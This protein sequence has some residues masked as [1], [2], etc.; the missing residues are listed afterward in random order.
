MHNPEFVGDAPPPQ[1]HDP[2][3][4]AV[5]IEEFVPLCAPLRPD[6][7]AARRAVSG[8]L[9]GQPVGIRQLVLQA[10]GASVLRA[11]SYRLVMRDHGGDCVLSLP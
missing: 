11:E 2:R 5:V 10:P 1:W 6:H 3:V 9:A 7:D 4:G 8:A